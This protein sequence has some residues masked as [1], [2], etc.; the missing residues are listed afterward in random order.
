MDAPT[1]TLPDP[2]RKWTPSR[3]FGL[4]LLTLLLL[5]GFRI[6]FPSSWEKF[7]TF[8]NSRVM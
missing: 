8:D 6:L 1:P 7:A 4:A 3:E 5:I 2:K